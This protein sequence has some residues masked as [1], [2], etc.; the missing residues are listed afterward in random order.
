MQGGKIN[1]WQMRGN[2]PEYGDT[3]PLSVQL[4]GERWGIYSAVTGNFLGNH[5]D[6]PSASAA[7]VAL[8]KLVGELNDR[9]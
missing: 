5:N 4:Q 3:Y 9:T 7:E 8:Y 1:R 2:A 6:Y